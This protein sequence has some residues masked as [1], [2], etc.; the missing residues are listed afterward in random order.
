MPTV[1]NG[2]VCIFGA[3]G[4]V[5]AVT[6]QSLASHYTLRCVDARSLE[7]VLA[8][9]NSHK[10][11]PKPQPLPAP[12]SWT[13]ADITD[14]PQVRDAISGCDAVINLSVNRVD[15]EAAFAVNVIGA[16]HVMKAALECGVKRV[17]HT[18]PESALPRFEGDYYFDHSIPDDAPPN[19]GTGLYPLTK[20]LSRT[21][22]D[23]FALERPKLEVLTFLLSRLR[24]AHETDGRDDDVVI[25]Y[26]TAWED[27]GDAFLCGLRAPP[28]PNPNEVFHICGRL[29]M[30]KFSPDKAERLLGWTPAHSF[31]K[32]Y[33]R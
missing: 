6:A 9:P 12:H 33:K 13:M 11:F 2:K 15:E 18:G 28:M 10:G 25:A 22:V 20:H 19:P 1:P 5:G 8:R 3:G 14:Y 32:F 23:A 21:V 4:P 26:S 31:T 16:Y 17:I 29:P 30:G 27:L 24:P 7:E